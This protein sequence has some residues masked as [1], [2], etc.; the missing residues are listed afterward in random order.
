LAALSA[1][2][3]FA[4]SSVS[5]TGYFDRGYTNVSSTDGTAKARSIGSSAGTTRIEFRGTEDLGAGNTAGFFVESDW[6]DFGGSSQTST[7]ATGQKAGFGNSENFLSFAVA[8]KGTLKFGAPNSLTF[9][10]A[11][12]AAPAFSTGLGSAYSI[13]F[14][15]A[16]GIST[17]ADSYAGIA[18][19]SIT[20]AGSV[21]TNNVGA[22]SIR[23]ANTLQY[24]T[25]TIAGF[26]AAVGYTP[27]NN[28]VSANSGN[29]NTIG[30]KE[31]L[32]NYANGPLT[33]G[34]SNTRFTVG[35]NG[36]NQYT[37]TLTGSSTQNG[38]AKALTGGQTSYQTLLSAGYQVLPNLK[39]HG[40]LTQFGSGDDTYKGKT[41][42]YG[43]TYTTG[44]W[45]V[46]G[47]I[48]K[49]DDQ[50]STDYDRK[51]T[52]FGVNYNWS[53]TTRTYFRYEKLNYATS[54]AAYAGSEATR[55]ALG[56]SKAF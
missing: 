14:A 42:Q 7:L 35:N 39:L 30:V 26:S 19:N 47:Q 16:N 52:G 40:G 32:V 25:P 48:A 5:I 21:T 10:N 4:Q 23:I 28:E 44:A 22:R 8:D 41:T 1:I 50:A 37:L 11:M 49:V 55:T 31:F 12:A 24:A 36:T 43:V 34:L 53:K 51:V 13:R 45:D 20:P 56:M 18:Q 6:A 54:Q 9:L 15:T 46:L 29:G 2:S 3:A 27:K 17:G 38:T 33:A